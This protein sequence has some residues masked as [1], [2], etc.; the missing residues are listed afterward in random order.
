MSKSKDLK[1]NSLSNQ[2]RTVYRILSRKQRKK[3]WIL[4]IILI[5]SSTAEFIGISSIVPYIGILS[6]PT[7]IESNRYLSFL[8][9]L[10]GFTQNKE[11]VFILGIYIVLLVI[12][13]SL[14][15]IV[16]KYL[17]F[18][19]GHHVGQEWT[20]RLY[21]YYLRKDYLFH[22]RHNTDQLTS[23]VTIEIG[24][25]VMGI[26]LPLLHAI[27]RT[28]LVVIFLIALLVYKPVITL[29]IIVILFSFYGFVYFLVYNKLFEYG[30]II[31]QIIAKRFRLINEG[32]GGIKENIVHGNLGYFI[33]KFE[34]T[35]KTIANAYKMKQFL[36][37]IPK[38]IVEM[39]LFGGILCVVIYFYKY[40]SVNFNELVPV[41]AF[42][43]IAGYRILPSL[44]TI[45]DALSQA[46]ST[47]KPLNIVSSDL[48]DA[49]VDIENISTNY[50]I[51]MEQNIALKN[52]KFSYS[53]TNN[54]IFT[55]INLNIIKGSLIGFA[56]PTG[57]GK[58][59]LV[60]LILGLINPE[61]GQLLVDG[62]EINSK[63]MKAWQNSL[64]YVPQ[65]IFLADSSIK[66][67]IAYGVEDDNIDENRVR[68]VIKQAQMDRFIFNLPKG[69]DARV[70]ERGI[71]LSGGQRQRIGIARALYRNASLL[72][73]DEA[74]S[75][76]D[77]ET[78]KGIMDTLF[79]IKKDI[80][81]ILIAHRLTTLKDCD[82]IYV[83]D[84]GNIINKGK[85]NELIKKCDLFKRMARSDGF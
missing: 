75:A 7:V 32:F 11:F 65:D 3:F 68:E 45:Y 62:V 18:S 42:F 49:S 78:E 59:T 76:L 64:G 73:F 74:T 2:I 6:N 13:S 27:A 34:S 19:F 56:G 72:I 79:E 57:C 10:T 20:T 67:N 70:G 71:Q 66:N 36:S 41:I 81:I 46:R 22:T 55:N 12:I 31:S 83:L 80:T 35:R 48:L 15:S 53:E 50:T 28:F 30:A 51:T 77:G 69:I 21:S 1:T 26:V 25:V 8:Y 54:N 24:R 61:R 47:Q 85:Y 43:V 39:I 84:Q 40:H 33:N 37:T 5:I 23:N 44:Q 17:T 4:Q 38:N 58:T 52:V 14:I 29:I 16:S 82:F 63:N 60:D 9:N